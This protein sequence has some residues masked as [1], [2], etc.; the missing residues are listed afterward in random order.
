M[1][2]YLNALILG[3]LLMVA[4]C[5]S[6]P[7]Q[8]MADARTELLAAEADNATRYAPGLMAEARKYLADAERRLELGDYDHARQYAEQARL[9]AI[10]AQNL[11]QRKMQASD[12]SAR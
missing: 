6:I 10:S 3:A 1:L 11:A 4:G 7:S 12:P 8:E 2:R 5:A 9:Y